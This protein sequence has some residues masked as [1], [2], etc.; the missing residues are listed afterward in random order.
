MVLNNSKILLSH[1]GVESAGRQARGHRKHRRVVGPKRKRAFWYVIQFTEFP[2]HLREKF[3][4]TRAG[5]GDK[6]PG[7]SL[8]AVVELLK[9]DFD[10]I[11]AMRAFRGFVFVVIEQ[12]T[13]CDA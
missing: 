3:I 11:H 13:T 8:R 2:T 6:R 1:V 9:L 5:T 12:F 10:N 4:E 7:A